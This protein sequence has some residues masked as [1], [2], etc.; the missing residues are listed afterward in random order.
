MTLPAA[1]A[2]QLEAVADRAPGRLAVHDEEG[3]LSYGE[4]RHRV[5]RCAQLLVSMGFRAGDRVAIGGPG[6][7]RQ[8]A[9]SIAVEGLGGVTASFA[10]EGDAAAPALF[11]QVHWVI[12]G[13]PQQVPAGV[14]FVALDDAFVQAWR[15]PLAAP[16]V[17]WP[18]LAPDTPQ[19][20]ART[21]GSSGAP[22]FLLHDRTA[23]EWWVA[24]AYSSCLLAHGA[25]SRML[26]LCPLVVGGAYARASACLRVGAAVL[27]GYELDLDALRP[28]ALFGLPAHLE[29][30]VAALPAG[31]VLP[32]PIAACVVGG[33]VPRWLRDRASA[34][35]GVAVHNRYGCN[36]AGPICE[37][38]D[39]DGVGAV[40][41]GVELRIL[42]DAGHD[43]PPGEVGTIAL[44]TPAVAGG[45][46][47][48]PAA[49]AQAF[50]DGWY[51][52]GDAGAQVAPGVLRLVGRRDDVLVVRGVKVACSLLE[53][54][55][56][57]LA[58]L[59]AAAVLSVQLDG[60][61]TTLGVAVVLAPGRTLAQA[62]AEIAPALADVAGL[63]IRLLALDAL[64]RLT[65][66]KLDRAALL[67]RFVERAGAA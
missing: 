7:G 26:L 6:L 60:G 64:P 40:M 8:L 50:R 23:Y 33:A 43:L 30:F 42:D 32:S 46:L 11:R 10:A 28:T 16:A 25:D 20:L 9:V 18:A 54:R 34:A 52:T 12:A 39:E 58:S 3:P 48:D 41:P 31:V 62:R 44:R 15:Q 5:V 4:F 61:R 36:E 56:A 19:R 55:L 59:A 29:G 14:R 37:A 21:S 65:A 17:A 67:R 38:I 51:I 57:G 45:Y 27:A 22:K 35:L 53:E 2:I 13:L 24:S 1:T 66:G 63:G 47:Q 49:S